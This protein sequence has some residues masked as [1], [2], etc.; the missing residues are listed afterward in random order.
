MSTYYIVLFSFSILKQ[1]R[2]T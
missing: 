2:D 1:I